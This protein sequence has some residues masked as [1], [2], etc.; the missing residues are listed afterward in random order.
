MAL[1]RAN[2][3][4]LAGASPAL[5]HFNAVADAVATVLGANYFNAAVNDLQVGDLIAVIGAGR[6]TLDWIH[7]SAVNRTTGVVTVLGAEG[8]TAT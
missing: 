7:V 5:F 1:V 8:V 6:T 2:L 4:K 3:H